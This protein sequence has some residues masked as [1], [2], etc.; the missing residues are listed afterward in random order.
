MANIISDIKSI[1]GK[2]EKTSVNLLKLNLDSLSELSNERTV[3]MTS[4]IDES[5]ADLLTKYRNTSDI[6]RMIQATSNY[7]F[8]RDLTTVKTMLGNKA[9]GY[10]AYQVTYMWQKLKDDA[11]RRRT[12]EALELTEPSKAIQEVDR[13]L[14]KARTAKGY[15]EYTIANEMRA[16]QTP[17]QIAYLA[18]KIGADALAKLREQRPAVFPTPT[19]TNSESAKTEDSSNAAELDSKSAVSLF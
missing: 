13:I 7:L 12:F 2:R 6:D 10:S 19:S 18:S 11:D 9:G 8:E 17:L 14:E 15:N 4:L 16:V 1:E 5:I 3:T